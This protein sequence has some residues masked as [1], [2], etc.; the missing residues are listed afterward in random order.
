[1][2][3]KHIEFQR[4][5]RVVAGRARGG[6]ESQQDALLCLHDPAEDVRLLVLA[7]GMGGD[8]AGELASDGVI[9]MARRLWQQR[10]WS[11]EPAAVFLETLCQEAHRELRRLRHGLS[12]GEP[13]STIVALL[14]R[15]DRA[16]W[17]HVGDSRLYHFIGR[18]CVD[19][20]RDHSLAELRV[21]RGEIR[22]EQAA[23]HADQNKLLRGL[24]G[25]RAP[26]VE[27]GGA[28]LRIG[29]SFA[30]C[31][32]GVWASLSAAELGR[33]AA[34]DDHEAALREALALA[35]DRGGEDGD[36]L[37]LILVRPLSV[38]RLRR[39][40]GIVLSRLGVSMSPSHT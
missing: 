8:G 12:H 40:A 5:P 32:D 9:A 11:R 22:P 37:A 7:D 35:A 20:T 21:Q 34:R 27:H 13:H 28:M 33:F 17:A 39:Y 3:D 4:L 25:D 2:P 26:Q 36:N 19:R 16:S 10:L 29:Q 1:M 15:G 6:R 18:R 23:H 31:S 30:L 24:G 14:L 38:G